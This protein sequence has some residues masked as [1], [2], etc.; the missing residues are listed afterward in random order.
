MPTLE[1][2]GRD[3]EV[4]DSFLRMTPEQQNATVDEIAQSLGGQAAPE[5]PQSPQ[6]QQG[7]AEL[8]AL[9]QNPA[10]IGVGEDMAR[11]GAAG[12]R[13]GT[14]G[15]I[16]QFGDAAQMQGDIAGWAAGKFG[17]SPETQETVSKWGSRLSP[18]GFAPTTDTLHKVTNE[19]IGE[20]YRP[21]TVA[22]EYTRTVGQFAPGAVAG[23]GSLGRKVAMTVV[24]AVAS[25]TAGQLTE[26]TKAEPYARAAAALVG[27]VASAG[28]A[29]SQVKQAAQ[30]A[31]TRE[32]LR[33]ESNRLYTT[34]REAGIR[35]DANE[36][37]NTV[38]RMASDLR[39]K[40]FRSS[41]AGAARE[42]IRDLADDIGR[43]PDFDDVNGMISS[44]GGK[45]RDLRA[46]GQHQEAAALD[47]IKDHLDDFESGAAMVSNKPMPREQFDLLRQSAR[48]TALK[49]IKARTLEEIVANADTYQAGREA[50][51]RNGISNLLRSKRGIQLFKGAERK[52]L[53]EVA[54]G[55][56]A[57]RT[58]SRF[59]FDLTKLSGN[60]TL[61]PTLGALG[62]GMGLGP[63]AGAGLAVAGTAA[64]AASPY[65][66]QRALD[67]ASAAIRSGRMNSPM[68]MKAQKAK[69]LQAL[70]RSLIAADSGENSAVSNSSVYQPN[71]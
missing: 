61:L 11:S 36:Y 52:E 46:Q 13:Q 8:S 40:G 57:L 59:G 50:G 42:V 66:T 2:N 58:L 1:I 14:E 33:E 4:D 18:F 43:S 68:M 54:Q 6:M 27:G 3:V 35:Y 63:I 19:G 5:Q 60:A 53:L 20:S 70:V 41:T 30:G 24:P 64:K 34:M 51:I 21:H 39:K 49:N 17:A 26:G 37:A 44:I 9:T 71:R 48:S 23:P 7:L 45:A 25:E 32:A 67:T 55:R 47:I 10:Q 69:Q 16:G 56:K 38:A 65:M 62:A 22:G 31:P 12:L 15:L 28:R 29:P